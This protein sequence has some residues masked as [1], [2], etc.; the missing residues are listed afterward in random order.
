MTNSGKGWSAR[1]I[2]RS[3]FLCVAALALCGCST[4]GSSKAAA[5]STT[6]TPA[7]SST[8]AA[9]APTSTSRPKVGRASAALGRV[10]TTSRPRSKARTT[11]TTAPAPTTPTT[12]ATTPPTPVTV[13]PPSSVAASVLSSA[14]QLV[15]S[16]GLRSQRHGRFHES[17]DRW[18]ARDHRD[19]LGFGREPH[20]ASVLLRERRVHPHRPSQ[21]FGGYSRCVA[22]QHDHRA[23]LRALQGDGAVVLPDRWIDD[24]PLRVE[25]LPTRGTRPDPSGD[26]SSLKRAP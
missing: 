15:R 1:R 21:L 9:S 6:G 24:R 11:A 5:S 25:R 2:A 4:S 23:G 22:K 16:E 12:P 26:A 17:S 8:T 7:A 13:A 19:R 3:A 20:A 18:A 14:E 10:T